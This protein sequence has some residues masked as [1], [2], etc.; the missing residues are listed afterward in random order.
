MTKFA[1]GTVM[2][3]VLIE[4]R[5]FKGTVIVLLTEFVD[6]EAMLSRIGLQ[7]WVK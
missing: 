5:F 6:R 4:F 3:E 2:E 1:D 7:T